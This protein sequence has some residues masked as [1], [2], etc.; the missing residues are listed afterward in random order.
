LAKKGGGGA[1]A[2]RAN[3]TSKAQGSR[4]SIGGTKGGKQLILG[5]REEHGLSD[6]AS[7]FSIWERKRCWGQ[8]SKIGELAKSLS[9][10]QKNL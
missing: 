2:H 10:S 4:T 3:G 1:R 5:N 6:G 7:H 9:T 8:T